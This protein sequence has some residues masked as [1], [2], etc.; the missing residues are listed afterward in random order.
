MPI[1]TPVAGTLVTS[2]ASPLAVPYPASPAA[3]D[4]L[5]MHVTCTAATMPTQPAGWLTALT[6][7]SGTGAQSPGAGV[8]YRV[9]DGTES[10][11]ISVTTGA[12][13]KGQMWKISDVDT[14][15]PLD[16]TPV[17]TKFTTGTAYTLTSITTTVVNCMLMTFG[18]ANAA[19]G[20]WTPP[21]T[22][23]G[24]WA[25]I[26]DD[27]VNVSSGIH[28]KIWT[29]SGATGTVDLVR[30]TSL[31]GHGIHLA[32]RPAAVTGSPIIVQPPRR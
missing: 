11:T 20:T 19:S 30:S 28:W 22:Q 6:S 15:T 17:T 21:T 16:T 2:S 29:G 8:F 31:R 10:G 1:G 7:Q 26:Q 12:T 9:S 5:V 23:G 24:G 32:L 25:E 13:N 27:A 14:T 18:V 4:L 3:G